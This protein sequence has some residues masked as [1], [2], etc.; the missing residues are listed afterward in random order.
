MLGGF[1]Q[2]HPLLL[3]TDTHCRIDGRLVDASGRLL[4][5]HNCAGT[6]GVSSAPLLTEKGGKWYVAAI[7]VAAETGVAGGI[8][9]VPEEPSKHLSRI[10]VL[11]GV[12]ECTVKGRHDAENLRFGSQFTTG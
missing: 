7:D 4:L 11:P 9:V 1:Q 2:D 8:A 10:D 6:D 3:M 12:K 5:R